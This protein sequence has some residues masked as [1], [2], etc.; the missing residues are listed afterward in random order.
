MKRT[1]EREREIE[2]KGGR[3]SWESSTKG[4]EAYDGDQS[5]CLG[6]LLLRA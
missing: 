3:A 1:K 6:R 4:L 5:C 2:I